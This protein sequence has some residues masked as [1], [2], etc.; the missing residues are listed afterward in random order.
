[1]DILRALPSV[2]QLLEED[3]ATALIAAHGRP[4]VR[5]AVQRVLEDERRQ[6]TADTSPARWARVEAT[7][8]GLR[9]PR[10]R[11]E[12]GRASCRERV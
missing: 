11:P 4:L 12:I 2:H 1:M 10:L 8:Q 9:R 7:I 3:P 5:F 6:A